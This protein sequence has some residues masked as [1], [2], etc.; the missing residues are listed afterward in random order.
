M[1]DRRSGQAV[2]HGRTVTDQEPEVVK[3]LQEASDAYYGGYRIIPPLYRALK[4]AARE[5]HQAGVSI[6]AI[7]VVCR[8]AVSEAR[9]WI[10]KPG[11]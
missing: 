8:V 1:G 5:A 9:Y 2:I 11:A 7:A 10:E 4:K 6:D 3:R